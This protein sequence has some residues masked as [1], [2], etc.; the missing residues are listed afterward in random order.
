MIQPNKGYLPF[1]K[2]SSGF[3]KYFKNTF[4]LVSEKVFRLL[5]SVFVGIWIARYLGPEV[6]GRLNYLLSIIGLFGVVASLGLDSIIVGEFVKSDKPM[7][8]MQAALFLKFFGYLIFLILIIVFAHLSKLEG[9]LFLFLLFLSFSVFFQGFNVFEMYFQS[10]VLGKYIVISNVLALSIASL[11]RVYLIQISSTL[12]LFIVAIV[13]ESF[14]IAILYLL[15]AYKNNLFT[16]SIL[17][18]PQFTI[19]KR[20]L[21]NSWPLLLSSL[22]IMIYMRTDQILIKQYLGDTQ[23]GIYSA[24]LR[25]SEGW[26]FL[27]TVIA[28][29]LYP[30]ILNSKMD[31][32][33]LYN[34]RLERLFVILIWGAILIAIFVSIF[35]PFVVKILYGAKFAG[36]SS[37]LTIHIWASVFVFGGVGANCWIL[38][39]NLQRFVNYFLVTGLVLNI[40]LNLLLIPQFGLVGSAF[41][42]LIAQGFSTFLAPYFFK[43]TRQQTIMLLKAVF[44]PKFSNILDFSKLGR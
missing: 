15:I 2:F 32:P 43:E 4:L 8:I 30:A 25:L 26:Y 42:T 14:L 9:S 34:L 7:E 6:F 1:L 12:F 44:S 33:E 21:S 13:F 39:E 38:A 36:A 31:D 29:S 22:V 11:Y 16:K 23:L 35:S 3:K 19:V 37:V 20:L 28:S 40:L 5:L 10:K 17:G 27:P 24:A 41:A 18:I